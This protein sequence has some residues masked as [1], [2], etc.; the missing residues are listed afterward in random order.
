[1]DQHFNTI[2]SHVILWN[3]NSEISTKPNGDRSI[4]LK[5]HLGQFYDLSRDNVSKWA[6]AFKCPPEHVMML[7]NQDYN[8]FAV[9]DSTQD[10]LIDM[11]MFDDTYKAIY[12]P[13]FDGSNFKRK[14]THVMLLHPRRN[15]REILNLVTSATDIQLP[16]G[17]D[18]RKRLGKR[19]ALLSGDYIKRNKTHSSF[20]RKLRTFLTDRE[21]DMMTQYNGIPGMYDSG[22]SVY[23]LNKTSDT[24]I[25]VC[26]NSNYLTK[27]WNACA[28]QF[29]DSY[30]N[31]APDTDLKTT[32]PTTDY[33]NARWLEKPMC[34]K[35][36]RRKHLV[37]MCDWAATNKFNKRIGNHPIEDFCGC[38]RELVVGK[39]ANYWTSMGNNNKRAL[40]FEQLADVEGFQLMSEDGRYITD[41]NDITSVPTACWPSCN[42]FKIN[43]SSEY[44]AGEQNLIKGQAQGDCP[45]ENCINSIDIDRG[46]VNL[47]SGG[48]N[49]SCQGGGMNS[50]DTKGESNYAT[51]L[52]I[53]VL[54]LCSCIATILV[55]SLLLFSRS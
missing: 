47:I 51:P 15:L 11:V 43:W 25:N 48:L 31:G 46:S 38:E 22:R 50:V 35:H 28:D 1:M 18:N 40:H 3:K 17:K 4:N 21:I 26:W 42:A 6:D 12:F 29:K 24:D 54:V 8:E 27:N 14:V 41:K 13:G 53:M 5:Q 36:A 55:A 44:R 49:Q 32:V 10:G 33:P 9:F 34:K 2:S 30:C 39:D 37:S 7:R 45:F 16:S 52:I 19:Y 23:G 20:M